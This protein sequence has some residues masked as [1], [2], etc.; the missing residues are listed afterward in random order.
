MPD[1]E[2]TEQIEAFVLTRRAV[3]DISKR[4]G[5]VAHRVD[6]VLARLSYQRLVR[7]LIFVRVVDQQLTIKNLSLKHCFN[8]Y[9]FFL[10]VLPVVFHVFSNVFQLLQVEKEFLNKLAN[11]H[12]VFD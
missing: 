4:F 6:H 8:L 2:T 3:L 10:N 7:V 11:I 1:F 12:V 9:F 5:R